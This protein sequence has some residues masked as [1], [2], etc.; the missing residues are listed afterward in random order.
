M[1]ELKLA[2]QTS[3]DETLCTIHIAD[4]NEAYSSGPYDLNSRWDSF[5]RMRRIK[6]VIEKYGT[7]P[8]NFDEKSKYVYSLDDEIDNIKDLVNSHNQRVPPKKVA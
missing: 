7:K 5:W 2:Y 1:V 6:K 3:R 4:G 8:I